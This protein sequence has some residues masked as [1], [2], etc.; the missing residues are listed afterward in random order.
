MSSHASKEHFAC[1]RYHTRRVS[2][3]IRFVV[4]LAGALVCWASPG[5]SALQVAAVTLEQPGIELSVEGNGL[6][7]VYNKPGL[8]GLKRDR[9]LF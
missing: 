8:R 3:V 9:L 1:Y 5:R 7:N 2:P 6:G 4:G